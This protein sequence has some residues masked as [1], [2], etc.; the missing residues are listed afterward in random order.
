M[1]L[2][3]EAVYIDS[4]GVFH[5]VI[6]DGVLSDDV[7]LK[8]LKVSGKLSFDKIFCDEI[9]VD[10]KCKGG[11]LT[12]KN[13]SVD[14]KVK[15]DSLK[16]EQFFELDG[17]PKIGNIEA[18]EIII[19]SNAGLIGAVKCRKLKIFDG[20]NFTVG[21]IKFSGKLQDAEDISRIN[22]KSIDADKV[23]LENC[24]VDIVRC[25]DAFIGSNCAIEK[26]FVAG[27]C[28]VAADSTV[29]ETIRI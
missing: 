1:K 9:T 8:R 18:D 5:K 27:E 16:V 22:I 12:A 7:I 28:K 11:S 17:K 4:A 3:G 6:G 23:E 21:G 26:L 13:F 25:Q 14:G 29:S 19:E 24:A 2:K 15:L 10:G 20:G